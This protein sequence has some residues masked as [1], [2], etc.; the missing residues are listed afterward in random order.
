[1][2]GV[3]RTVDELLTPDSLL[4]RGWH[5]LAVLMVKL[6]AA[7]VEIT[8]ADIAKVA[9]LFPEGGP[10]LKFQRSATGLTLSIHSLQDTLA[11]FDSAGVPKE[12]RQ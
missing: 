9:D 4:L 3:V 11:A 2:L 1:M 7:S 12:T 6:D 10:Q 5:V 8:D